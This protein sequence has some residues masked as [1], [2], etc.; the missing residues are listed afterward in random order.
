MK[1]APAE[2]NETPDLVFVDPDKRVQQ[3]QAALQHER[4]ISS[5]IL[6]TV[7][8]L[9]VVL[10][11]EFKIVRFNQSCEVS[12]GYLFSE[13]KDKEVWP[14][15]FTD[16]DADPFRAGIRRLRK[17]APPAQFESYWKKRDGSAVVISWTV[18]ALFDHASAIRLI[19]A[20][21]IDV[22]EN[23]R[24][25][26]AVIEISGRE[27]RRIG[28]DLHDGLGQ[29]LTGIA[30]LA[31]VQEQKLAEKSLP[32][33]S[34]AG[35]I[36]DLVNQAI[37][38]TRELARGLLPV[39]SGPYGLLSALQEWVAEVQ[40]I[41]RI[42]CRFE[43]DDPVSIQDDGM[44]NHL[45]RIAQEAVHNA[46]RHGKAKHIAIGLR[47]AEEEGVLTIRDDGSG[48]SVERSSCAGM[49]LRIMDYRARMIGGTLTVGRAGERGMLVACLFPLRKRNEI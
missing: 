18:T 46:I 43:C 7:P 16:E 27:Q 2:L 30:F 10:D 35:K 26:N 38:K 12:T 41:F 28:Q 1:N 8:A 4:S 24:L 19:I 5:A 34:D 20:T 15:F 37:Y 33:A 23:K 49:G 21:G 22:T 29:H 31:K 11:P 39:L 45:F 13:L 40:D 36:V 3:A 6:D 14:L 32:E 42:E 47:G 48:V 17:N 25:E 9:V 44:A